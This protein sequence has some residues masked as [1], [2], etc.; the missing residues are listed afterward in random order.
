[1]GLLGM[2]PIPIDTPWPP[3]VRGFGTARAAVTRE[4]EASRRR[5]FVF[6]FSVQHRAVVLGRIRER[7]EIFEGLGGVKGLPRSREKRNE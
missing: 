6:F 2:V 1:M 3:E 5:I 7:I 4:R